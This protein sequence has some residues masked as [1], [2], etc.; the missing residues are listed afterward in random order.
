MQN[1]SETEVSVA[2]YPFI[3]FTILASAS[4]ALGNRRAMESER[5]ASDKREIERKTAFYQLL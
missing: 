3:S 5:V 2:R 1:E 4:S